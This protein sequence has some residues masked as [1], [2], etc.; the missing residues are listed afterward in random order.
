MDY[1]GPTVANFAMGTWIGAKGGPWGAL[2]GAIDGA[3]WGAVAGLTAAAYST[4][5]Q[6]LI[7]AANAAN[8]AYIEAHEEELQG[9]R[10]PSASGSRSGP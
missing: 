8:E 4:A 6:D 5:N 10:T 3:L 7:D 9:R 1:P 2:F